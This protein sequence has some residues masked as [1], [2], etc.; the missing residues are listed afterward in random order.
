MIDFELIAQGYGLVEAPRVDRQNRLLFSDHLYGG[1][2][3]REV[4]GSIRALIPN[5]KGVGGIAFG[6]DDSLIVSG[7]TVA[8]W[9]EPTGRLRDVS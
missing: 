6:R 8:V 4:D 5:R 9:S 3:R 1:V 7:E 2:Y